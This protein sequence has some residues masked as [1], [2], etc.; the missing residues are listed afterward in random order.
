MLINPVLQI[1]K[2]KIGFSKLI[3]MVTKSVPDKSDIYWS[4]S[5]WFKEKEI[6]IWCSAYASI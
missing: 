3:E 5:R 4:S 2:N 1:H 6:E